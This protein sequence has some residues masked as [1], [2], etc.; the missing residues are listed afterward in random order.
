MNEKSNES[1][2]GKS[3]SSL[4][5]KRRIRHRQFRQ[6]SV[7]GHLEMPGLSCFG[8]VLGLGLEA[9]PSG[10]SLW[11]A[12]MSRFEEFLALINAGEG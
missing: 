8:C 2:N 1:S 6:F 12:E 4:S 10:M 3:L 7:Y 5:F 11:W 9:R